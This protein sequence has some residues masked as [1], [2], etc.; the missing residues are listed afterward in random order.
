MLRCHVKLDRDHEEGCTM[1]SSHRYL[2]RMLGGTVVTF[3]LATTA[4]CGATGKSGTAGK[5]GAAGKSFSGELCHLISAGEL[6]AAAIDAPCV[7]AN[8]SQTPGR[9]VYSAQWG[10]S[11]AAHRFLSVSVTKYG[12][13]AAS[14]LLGAM[15]RNLPPEGR[16]FKVNGTGSVLAQ[17]LGRLESPHTANPKP[18]EVRLV[19]YKRGEAKFIVGNY[20]GTVV[21]TDDNPSASAKALEQALIPIAD[22][23]A[24]QL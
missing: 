24:A 14:F 22:T 3:A 20:S 15:A 11:L 16:P 5:S 6:S 4:G 21:L 19:R 18:S 12:G 8:T 9:T 17:T 13:P 2:R 1:L 10:A 23:V 7:Q